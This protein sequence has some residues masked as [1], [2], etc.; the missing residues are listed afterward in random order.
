MITVGI[1]N[2]RNSLS[3][4]LNLVKKGEK[5]L[6]T[7]HNKVIA[8]IIPPRTNQTKSDM[9]QKYLSEQIEN[10]TIVKAT[11]NNILIKKDKN[12]TN[13]INNFEDIYNETRSERS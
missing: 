8:E 6:I 13:S 3:Q 10:G 4:Y 11:Q 12:K 1:R 7:D 5:I 9:L 2:L